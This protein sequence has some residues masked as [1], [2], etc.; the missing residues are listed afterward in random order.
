[1]PHKSSERETSQQENGTWSGVVH[2]LCGWS[3]DVAEQPNQASA[4]VSLQ[5]AWLHHREVS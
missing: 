5:G 2:C 1:M 4:E 3:F